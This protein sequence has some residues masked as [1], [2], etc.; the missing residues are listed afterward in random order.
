MKKET[1]NLEFDW[2]DFS[3]AEF[4]NAVAHGDEQ[5][6]DIYGFVSCTDGPDKFLIDI[7]FEHYDS[8]NRGFEME[9]YEEL[10]EGGHGNWYRGTRKVRSAKNYR[11]FVNRAE[12]ALADEIA[13]IKEERP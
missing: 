1:K 2:F 4:L 12:K 11:S 13:D 6:D 3:E 8:R 7:H 10:P 9:I 5:E